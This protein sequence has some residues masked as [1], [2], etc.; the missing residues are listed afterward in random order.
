M[1]RKPERRITHRHVFSAPIRFSIHMADTFSEARMQNC[2]RDGIGFNSRVGFQPGDLIYIKMGRLADGSIP[3]KRIPGDLA[4]VRWCRKTA[5]R[6]V[7]ALFDVGVQ[8]PEP[9]T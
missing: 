7:A 3:P 1:A 2:S 5:R 8:F 6:N 9:L 4:E